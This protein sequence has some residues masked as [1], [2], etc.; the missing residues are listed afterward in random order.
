VIISNRKSMSPAYVEA[1]GTKYSIIL[2]PYSTY[3]ITAMMNSAHPA[4]TSLKALLA[5][6]S[7][8]SFFMI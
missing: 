7:L 4:A 6:S 5:N 2:T 3:K 1:P 8:S